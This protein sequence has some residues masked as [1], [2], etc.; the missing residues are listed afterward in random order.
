M[1]GLYQY[2]RTIWKNP[3]RAMKERYSDQLIGWRKESAITRV[4]RPTRLDRARSAGYKAKQGYIVARVRVTKGT[5]KRPKIKA[6]RRPKRFVHRRI[7]KQKGKQRIA[8]ERAG[9]KYRGLEVLNSFWVGADGKNEWYEVILI[10]PTH[11]RIVSSKAKWIHGKQHKGRVFR[12]KTSAG[13]KTRG[14]RK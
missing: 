6:G 7:T 1:K 14:L 12:G 8:E 13:K 5:S 2:I 3:K 4:D 10:D 9:R 11:T